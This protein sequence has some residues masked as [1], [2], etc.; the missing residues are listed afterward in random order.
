MMMMFPTF[1]DRTSSWFGF[2]DIRSGAQEKKKREISRYPADLGERIVA[3]IGFQ[4]IGHLGHLKSDN[5]IQG[6]LQKAN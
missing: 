4:A 6:P 3:E 1:L 5:W 2:L